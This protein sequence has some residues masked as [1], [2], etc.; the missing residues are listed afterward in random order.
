M[1]SFAE[2]LIDLIG[3][4]I[5]CPVEFMRFKSTSRRIGAILPNFFV[6]R[7]LSDL[8]RFN[9]KTKMQVA[10]PRKF[11]RL[12]QNIHH[13]DAMV[14]I[15]ECQRALV[16][17]CFESVSDE[18]LFQ[19]LC[20]SNLL[21]SQLLK[22]A[23]DM[24]ECKLIQRILMWNCA[25]RV[26]SADMIRIAKL[27]AA[28][29]TDPELFWYLHKYRDLLEEV[30]IYELLRACLSRKKH[31]WIVFFWK[32]GFKANL[33]SRNGSFLHFAIRSGS[34]EIVDLALT[35]SRN[36]KER[37]RHGIDPIVFSAC[38]AGNP[39]ILRKVLDAGYRPELRDFRGRTGLMIL[40]EQIKN[41]KIRGDHSPDGSACRRLMLME[42]ILTQYF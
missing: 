11:L 15:E 17:S 31:A 20:R 8:Y 26:G 7:N 9:A 2:E 13:I 21:A 3:G 14:L 35:N 38:K 32:N 40:K 23:V 29:G 1:D 6:F 30:S 27:F 28:N 22:Y 16:V 42:S 39:S 10:A 24:S 33:T 37:Y 5:P 18:T 4:F 34:E 41:I 25:P 19:L 12:A 36:C